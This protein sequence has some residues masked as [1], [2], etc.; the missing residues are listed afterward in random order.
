MKR[1]ALDAVVSDLVRERDDWTCQYSGKQFPD[2]KGRDVHGS[3]FFSR[4][5][6]SVR[7]FPDNIVTLSAQWHDFVGKNP[8]A[9]VALVKRL[10]GDVR[11]EALCERKNRI[12]R[13]RGPDKTAMRKHYANEL[14]RL[15]SLRAQGVTGH[16]EVVAYD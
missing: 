8:N 6:L 1:D 9:H 14:E 15:L 11:Y 2:R 7:Y 5:Y 3:H 12:Y 13:Y 4:I 16:I 10:L